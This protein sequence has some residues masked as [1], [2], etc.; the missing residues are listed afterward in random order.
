MGEEL[1]GSGR[2]MERGARPVAVRG[3]AKSAR[4]EPG[5]AFALLVLPAATSASGA[6]LS[7]P[8][9]GIS[10]AFPVLETQKPVEAPPNRA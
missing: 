5:V 4:G 1:V 3:E 6:F 10:T 7:E 2:C 8:F 9:G